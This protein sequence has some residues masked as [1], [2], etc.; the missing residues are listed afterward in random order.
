MIDKSYNNVI[1]ALSCV[2]YSQ[3]F[4]KSVSTGNIDDIDTSGGVDGRSTLYPLVHIV[5][6]GVV[7]G[8]GTLS[9]NFN[10]LAMDLVQPD[11]S[12]EQ[13]VLS[14]TLSIITSIISEFRHGKNLEIAPDNKGVLAQISEDVS[15]EPFTEYLDNV[16]SGWNASFNI[17]IPFQYKACDSNNI[18]I[19]ANS[20]FLISNAKI[21]TK[22][23]NNPLR[24]PFT[25][26][27]E[28]PELIINGDFA[29]DSD[30]TKG[31]GWTISGGS[32]SHTGGASY[33]SQDVLQANTLYKVSI[34]ITAVSGGFVQIYMG[35]SPASVLISVIGN[36]TYNFTSQSVT[37][38][39]FALRSLGDITIDNVS[40]KELP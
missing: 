24:I 15:I 8:T 33:L 16:V 14:D 22:F 38:L 13:E 37:T 11:S 32:A 21:C 35:N 34:N 12:N 4:V 26:D 17:E 36:Y 3:G 6:Q 7:A 9:F 31:S 2:A 29:T 10:I 23:I 1:D 18:S 27:T 20:D 5:P 25:G 39:G 28:G 40:V 30:W 19:D